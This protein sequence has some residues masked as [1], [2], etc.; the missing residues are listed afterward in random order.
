MT[1]VGCGMFYHLLSSRIE[2]AALTACLSAERALRACHSWIGLAKS[3]PLTTVNQ[4]LA[5]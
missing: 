3:L 2:M 1:P 5:P 4:A